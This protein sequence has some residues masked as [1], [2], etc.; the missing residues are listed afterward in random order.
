M[1]D[2]ARASQGQVFYGAPYHKWT[3]TL[4]TIDGC[5]GDDQASVEINTL[6]GVTAMPLGP[7]N[8]RTAE[9]DIT[10]L[11]SAYLR[12]M[13]APVT[14]GVVMIDSASGAYVTG[15]WTASLTI[16][17][18]LTEVTATFGAPVCP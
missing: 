9:A 15:S 4:S 13:A 11:P 10:T 2:S 14:S 3:I 8:L 1:V 6:S 18:A 12:Y 5:G 16:G 7:I 17:G